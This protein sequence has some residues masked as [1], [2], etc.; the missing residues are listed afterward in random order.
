VHLER[1][2]KIKEE[3]RDCMILLVSRRERGLSVRKGGWSSLESDHGKEGKIRNL[4]KKA[5]KNG[6]RERVNCLVG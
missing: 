5:G 2:K 1:E 6:K 3:T 4:F